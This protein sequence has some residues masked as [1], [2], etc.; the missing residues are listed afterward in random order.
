MKRARVPKRTETMK[1]P[2]KRSTCRCAFILFRSLLP[3]QYLAHLGCCF[4]TNDVFYRT[5]PSGFT[6]FII[7]PGTKKSDQIPVPIAGQLLSPCCFHPNHV[8]VRRAS[9]PRRSNNHKKREISPDKN[10]FPSVHAMNCEADQFLFRVDET[11]GRH[12]HGCP[13]QK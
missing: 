6:S 9:A 1:L 11:R 4:V 5:P 2:A 3:L 10:R 8:R 7:R 12:S 13:E